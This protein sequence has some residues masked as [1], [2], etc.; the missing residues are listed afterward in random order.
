MPWGETT[1]MD[2]KVYVIRDYLTNNY[3]ITQLAEMHN[4]SRPTVYKYISLYKKHGWGC[5]EERSRAPHRI[6]HKTSEKIEKLIIQAR[7]RRNRGARK[8]ITKLRERYP[9]LDFPAVSTANDILKRNGLVSTK[10]RRKRIQPN[11]PILDPKQPNDTWTIDFKGEFW[12]G[13][14]EKCYPLTLCD[15]YSRYILGIKALPSPNYEDTKKFLTKMFKEYGLPNQIL[16]DNGTPFAA[17]QALGRLSRLAVWWITLGITPV[18][19]QPGHPEQNARHERMHRELKKETAKPPAN[20]FQGQ[21]RKIN[22]FVDDYNNERPHEGLND[23]YPR[24]FYERSKKE[25]PKK[26]EGPEYPSY[27]EVRLV[28]VNS[29]IRWKKKWVPVTTSLAG[30]YIGLDEVD[31]GVWRVHFYH[32]TLGYLDERKMRI[33]DYQRRYHRN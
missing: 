5:L 17:P 7:K 33:M 8:I 23:K 29:G 13:C 32:L 27:Y 21:Q 12:L 6:P 26:V 19:T 30:Q 1:I 14:K 18:L 28:S 22:E 16:S 20:T 10:K 9:N 3:S 15:P 11:K 4:I 24:E 25:M 2:S 31:D